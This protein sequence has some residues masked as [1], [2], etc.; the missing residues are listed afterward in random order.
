MSSAVSG[1]RRRAGDHSRAGRSDEAGGDSGGRDQH[2]G[3]R[4][5]G[6]VDAA[7]VTAHQRAEQR[8]ADRSAGLAHRIQH[9]GGNAGT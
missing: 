8:D 4:L 7:P 2:Q 1:V 3:T 6:F 5:E 9:P